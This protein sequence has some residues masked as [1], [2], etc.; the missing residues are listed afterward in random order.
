MKKSMIKIHPKRSKSVAISEKAS[1]SLKKDFKQN[2][3]TLCF[4]LLE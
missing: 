4:K 1:S 2:N 3:F